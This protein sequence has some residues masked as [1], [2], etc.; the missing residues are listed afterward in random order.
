MRAL[1]VTQ[2]WASLIALGWKSHET[3]SWSTSYR[4][5]LAIHAS[6]GWP[7]WARHFWTD[8]RFQWNLPAT[9]PLGSV[10]A[11]ARVVDVQPVEVVVPRIGREE[12]EL[13]DYSDGRFAWKLADVSPTAVPIPATGALGLWEWTPPPGL[14]ERYL[15]AVA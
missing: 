9:L 14:L 5:V 13:G 6:K 2:P 10:V 11:F 1:S 12:Y 4:G 15:E 8:R 7:V 3:R